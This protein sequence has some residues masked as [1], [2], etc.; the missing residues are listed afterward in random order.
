LPIS[1]RSASCS[2]ARL[3]RRSL[4]SDKGA[5]PH[6]AQRKSALRKRCG[7]IGSARTLGG[8]ARR[9]VIQRVCRVSERERARLRLGFFSDYSVEKQERLTMRIIIATCASLVALSSIS[10]QAAPLPLTKAGPTQLELV[11][12]GCGYGYRRN[13]W[14]DE[15]GYWRR[16]RCVPKSWGGFLA[17]N[18]RSN[19]TRSGKAQT[20]PS[21]Q[22]SSGASIA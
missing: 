7:L 19:P 18:F 10:V 17:S 15:C 21:S 6:V 3:S 13:L 20:R 11:A 9:R 2:I 16:G 8:D 5:D 4:S 14:R 1:T 22:S 12:E